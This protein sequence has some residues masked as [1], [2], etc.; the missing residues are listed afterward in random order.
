MLNQQLSSGVWHSHGTGSGSTRPVLNPLLVWGNC[1]VSFDLGA[2]P[3]C[4]HPSIATQIAFPVYDGPMRILFRDHPTWVI[5]LSSRL[6]NG[7]RISVGDLLKYLYGFIHAEMVQDQYSIAARTEDSHEAGRLPRMASPQ[8][9]FGMAPSHVTHV[10][11]RRATVGGSRGLRR[12]DFMGT[13]RVFVGLMPPQHPQD[14]SAW[15]V[16]FADA[17]GMNRTPTHPFT[18]S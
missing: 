10:V 5:E 2:P 4:L 18:R 6:P 7:D 13:K 17:N 3:P 8:P 1:S 12:Y 14:G 15:Y 11:D 16:V 9:S